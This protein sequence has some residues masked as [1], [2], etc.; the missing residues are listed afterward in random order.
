M[1]KILKLTLLIIIILLNSLLILKF[2]LENLI[3]NDYAM[4]MTGIKP[5]KFY[6]AD[7]LYLHTYWRIDRNAYTRLYIEACLK[8]GLIP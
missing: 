5:D 2:S 8:S 6:W 4:R 3:I 7:N 1:I